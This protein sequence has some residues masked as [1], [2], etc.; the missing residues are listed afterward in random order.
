VPGIQFTDDRAEVLSGVLRA[1][2]PAELWWVFI[3]GVI[4]LLLAEV[5]LTRRRALAAGD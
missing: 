1:P 3:A 2:H 5:W 4:L